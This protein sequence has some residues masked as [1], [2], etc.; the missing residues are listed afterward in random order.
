M[1]GENVKGVHTK[2]C[3]NGETR[4]EC[5]AHCSPLWKVGTL[6]VQAELE[7]VREA[8][9]SWRLSLAAFGLVWFLFHPCLRLPSSERIAVRTR[10]TNPII[11]QSF[12]LPN[13]QLPNAYEWPRIRQSIQHFCL[14]L[15]SSSD[16]SP[17]RTSGFLEKRKRRVGVY[18]WWLEIRRSNHPT[19]FPTQVPTQSFEAA[20]KDCVATDL[21]QRFEVTRPESPKPLSCFFRLVGTWEGVDYY[22]T[23]GLRTPLS[24]LV[25]RKKT[26]TYH[27]LRVQW[28]EIGTT[29]ADILFSV[30]CYFRWCTSAWCIHPLPIN[31]AEGIV[32]RLG[33]IEMRLRPTGRIEARWSWYRGTFPFGC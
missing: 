25:T 3:V 30:R 8:V 7:I 1:D 32:E 15:L 6:W 2:L 22:V 16:L 31:R 19:Y 20:Q 9:G 18:K 23:G 13:D 11:P 10:R 27:S 4:E 21:A 17:T 29:V 14:L 5:E 33:A 12:L 24:N 28:K 26:C